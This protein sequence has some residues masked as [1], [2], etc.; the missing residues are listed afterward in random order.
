[1][2]HG[3]SR[4]GSG[5]QSKA[6]KYAGTINRAERKIA[7]KLPSIIDRM[8]E[9]ADGVTVQVVDMDGGVNIYT[10]PP[11]YKACAYLIDRILGKVTERKEIKATVDTGF[12][13]DLSDDPN[14]SQP[15]DTASI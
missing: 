13:I 12:V 11:D 10:K 6:T 14:Q 4:E 7:D 5:R 1:M 2:A 9:L 8:F 3:G 15:E